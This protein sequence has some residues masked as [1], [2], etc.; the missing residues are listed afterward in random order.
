MPSKLF[1]IALPV[2]NGGAYLRGCVESILAQR[3]GDFDLDIFD[4]A[5]TDG[6]TEWLTTLRDPRVRLHPADRPLSITENWARIRD[7]PKNEYLTTIGHDDLLDPD[8]LEIISGLIDRHPDAGLYLTHFRLIDEEGKFLRHCQPMPARETGA[9][10]VAARL[11][12]LRDS[13]GTGYVLR[14][15]AYDAIG[16][17]PPFPKLLF[18]DDALFLQAIG[19]SYRATALEEAFSYRWHAASASTTSSM[20]EVFGALER[21]GTLLSDQ[22]DG[23]PALAE[24]LQ[25]YFP[26]Y[27]A[28]VGWHWRQEA[29]LAAYHARTKLDPCLDQRVTALASLFGEIPPLPSRPRKLSARLLEGATRSAFVWALFRVWRAQQKGRAVASR[30]LSVG[31]RREM[32]S[33]P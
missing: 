3:C 20:G 10:F 21:Y 14:S 28:H 9:E 2:R 6:T 29:L 27:A 26:R 22:R 18:A 19:A 4:N 8:F 16:G 32:T 5:S 13:F 15:A 23:D 7:I 1:T 30:W 24:V 33:K 31:S 11:C 17:I 12:E 25:R